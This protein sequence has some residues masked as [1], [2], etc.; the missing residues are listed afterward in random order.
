MGQATGSTGGNRGATRPALVVAILAA[1]ATA[2]VLIGGG[3]R[4]AA[5]ADANFCEDYALSVQRFAKRCRAGGCGCA[6]RLW[7]DDFQTNYNWCR[8]V[9]R[10]EVDRASNTRLIHLRRCGLGAPAAIV[11]GRKGKWYDRD[12]ISM[13]RNW[14]CPST[15]PVRTGD[16]CLKRCRAGYRDAGAQGRPVCFRCPSGFPRGRMRANGALWC[17][18]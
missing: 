18:R 17:F 12:H 14:P 11:E 7:N 2:T 3:M 9:H 15:F 5:A 10:T 1:L 16:L 8:S 4:G 6:G 13:A